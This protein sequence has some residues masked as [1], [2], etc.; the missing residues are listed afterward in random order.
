MWTN[1]S[2]GYK[3]VTTFVAVSKCCLDCH[4]MYFN[5]CLYHCST[6]GRD[7]NRED[8]PFPSSPAEYVSRSSSSAVASATSTSSSTTQ[9]SSASASSS[10]TSK[11]SCSFSLSTT[12]T[13]STVSSA[14]SSSESNQ[15]I[16][17]AVKLLSTELQE[18]KREL[19]SK[20][21]YCIA[22]FMWFKS[23]LKVWFYCRSALLC[24]IL[25]YCRPG[26]WQTSHATAATPHQRPKPQQSSST[27][28]GGGCV[29][30]R[31]AGCCGTTLPWPPSCYDATIY[32]PAE[33]GSI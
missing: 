3:F 32:R 24:L 6:F 1:K 4:A 27:H 11:A 7:S 19:M 22:L 26:K 18:S 25:F 28:R 33:R 16:L 9:H 23:I 15:S 20:R 5:Y 17:D 14:N 2:V 29:A 31:Q 30:A 8:I 10:A 13:R 12:P 21:L